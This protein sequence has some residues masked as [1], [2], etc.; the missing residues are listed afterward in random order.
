MSSRTVG[1]GALGPFGLT[2][3]TC[4]TRA[5]RLKAANGSGAAGSQPE[6]GVRRLKRSLTTAEYSLSS[7]AHFLQTYADR[8]RDFATVPI[9]RP[10]LDTLEPTPTTVLLSAE[11]AKDRL[12]EMIE[13]LLSGGDRATANGAS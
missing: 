2:P 6:L 8:A 12:R 3:N 9:A 11:E 4:R 5:G 7:R 1:D 10:A 13:D